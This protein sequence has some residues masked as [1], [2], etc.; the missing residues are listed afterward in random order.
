MKRVL[1]SAKSSKLWRNCLVF[2]V[3]SCALIGLEP[4]GVICETD[5]SLQLPS[6]TLVGLPSSLTQESRDRIRAA[7]S[8]SGF[9]WP[10][11]KVTINLLPAQLPKWGSHFE[12]PMALGIFGAQLEPE[13]N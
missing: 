11:R 4:H 10:Q 13:K 12:L 9:E 7:V 6:F 1:W 8:N 5:L 3:E 2:S